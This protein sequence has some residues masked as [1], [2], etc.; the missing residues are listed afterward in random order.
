MMCY[1][2]SIQ[3]QSES[4]PLPVCP[5]HLLAIRII[6]VFKSLFIILKSCINKFILIELH[7]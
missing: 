7:R 1:T 3:K 2:I 6:N 4:F 5:S